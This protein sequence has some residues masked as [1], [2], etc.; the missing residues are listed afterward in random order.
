ML[1]CIYGQFRSDCA[2]FST[3]QTNKTQ[4]LNYLIYYQLLTSVTF[5]GIS[6]TLYFENSICVGREGKTN[7]EAHLSYQ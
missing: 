7:L 4:T 1:N 2:H 3:R 5:I 6:C